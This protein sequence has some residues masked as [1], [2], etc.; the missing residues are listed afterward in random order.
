VATADSY[1]LREK[2]KAG[3][4]EKQRNRKEESDN[5]GGRHQGRTGENLTTITGKKRTKL[6]GIDT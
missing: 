5:E 2:K 6:D 3:M 4:L 1:R